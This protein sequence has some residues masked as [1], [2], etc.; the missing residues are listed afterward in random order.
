MKTCSTRISRFAPFVAAAMIAAAGLALAGPLNPPAGP[1]TSTMKTMAEVEPRTAINATNTPGDASRV[2]TISQPGSYYLTSNVTVPS[3]KSGINITVPNVTIDMNGFSIIG[4]AGSNHGL[5]TSQSRVTVRNGRVVSMGGEGVL[6]G[7]SANYHQDIVVENL[8]VTD[9]GA[10]GISIGSGTIRNCIANRN[11]LIGI[12]VISDMDSIVENCAANDNANSGIKVRVGTVRGCSASNNATR[13]F[14][15]TTGTITQCTAVGNG[16]GFECG[17]TTITDS[18][19]RNNPIGIVAATNSIVRGNNVSQTTVAADT[20]GIYVPLGSSGAL[21]EG[22]M[23]QRMATAISCQ[24]TNNLVIRNSFRGCTTAINAVA[25]NR[26][27][28]LI[29]G[30]SSPAINGNSGGGLGTTDPNANILY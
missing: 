22:N 6:F 1:V 2:F 26:V 21:I 23:I 18:V 15:L 9:C 11:G 7:I 28:L 13:G 19:A 17:A 10:T 30:T 16:I 8:V 29:S 27:G 20:I 3:G 25:G 12:D 24:G 4:A 14:S 5:I